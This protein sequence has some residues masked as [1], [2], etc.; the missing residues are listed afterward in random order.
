MNDPMVESLLAE[1]EGYVRRGM[2]DR[3]AQVDQ[4]LEHHGYA[5]KPAEP[6]PEATPE[7][8]AAKQRAATQDDSEQPK[9]RGRP[10]KA[11]AEQPPK[12]E[13]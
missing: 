12:D 8:E 13:S 2:E 4:Q 6:T 11:T 7:A 5:V 3:V 1:R 10:P 9:K